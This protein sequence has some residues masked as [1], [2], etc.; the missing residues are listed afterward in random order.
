MF[1]F[2]EEKSS[3]ET[4]VEETAAVL[5]TNETSDEEN[6][7]QND[8]NAI[9]ENDAVL[10]TNETGDEENNSLQNNPEE[11][12]LFLEQMKYAMKK[13]NWQKKKSE[14]DV[15][16]SLKLYDYVGAPG[17]VFFGSDFEIGAISYKNNILLSGEF[18]GGFS[19]WGGGFNFGFLFKLP[20]N[21]LIIPGISSGIWIAYNEY[22]RD[23]EDGKDVYANDEN[24]DLQIMFGGPFV[25]Y[26]IGKN[27]RF[28]EICLKAPMGLVEKYGDFSYVS[29]GDY[30]NGGYWDRDYKGEAF[31]VNINVSIGITVL[32]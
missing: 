19:N 1:C 29:N 15:Y 26:L 13:A 17:Y 11:M 12:A 18:G 4:G 2:A 3:L 20:N 9:E 31:F 27:K 28:F 21:H 30:P 25:K 14:R 6:L 10:E 7:L 22:L 5:E 8:E 23:D 32:F 16:L 24:Y